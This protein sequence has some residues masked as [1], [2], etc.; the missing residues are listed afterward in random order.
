VLNATHQYA[1]QHKKSLGRRVL[2]YDFLDLALIRCSIFLEE[3]V[4][5]GLGWGV[6]VWLVEQVLDT[7]ENLLNGDRWLP[8]IFFIQDRQADRAGGVDVGVEERWD[9]FAYLGQ[10]S[11]T[12]HEDRAR[13]LGW[14]CW[15]LCNACQVIYLMYSCVVRLTIRENNAQLEQS[16]LPQGLLLAGYATLPDLQIKDASLGVPLGLCVETERVITSPLLSLLLEAHLT[17]SHVELLRRAL[18]VSRLE[19]G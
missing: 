10:L 13:T 5:V 4:S 2:P 17:Q 1:V 19:R 11:Q 18:L 14:F 12:Q 6:G 9:E 3:V 16:T 7:E 8:C 15:V